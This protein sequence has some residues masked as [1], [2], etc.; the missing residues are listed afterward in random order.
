M[1]N[2]EYHVTVSII[3]TSQAN[4]LK[5]AQY[6]VQLLTRAIDDPDLYISGGQTDVRMSTETP[7][8]PTPPLSHHAFS[9]SYFL[10]L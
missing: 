8:T 1:Y 6:T 9:N 3:L 4:C 5:H 10:P 7:A 2:T